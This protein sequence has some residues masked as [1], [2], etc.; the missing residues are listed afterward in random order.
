MNAGCLIVLADFGESVVQGVPLSHS[1]F[2]YFFDSVQVSRRK[3]FPK[4]LDSNVG[5]L[6]LEPK[7]W[8]VFGEPQ[9]ECGSSYLL[10]ANGWEDTALGCCLQNARSKLVEL[11][12]TQRP[13]ALRP[14]RPPTL[15]APPRRVPAPPTWTGARSASAA[16]RCCR[17]SGRRPGGSASSRQR[18]A[19]CPPTPSEEEWQT[20]R[21]PGIEP[22][23]IFF[24]RKCP[25]LILVHFGSDGQSNRPFWGWSGFFFDFLKEK[26]KHRVAMVGFHSGCAI[27]AK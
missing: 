6:F 13:L 26:V 8:F 21:Q 23:R 25:A 4:L 18:F 24:L 15:Q 2:P 1:H 9:W 27:A 12:A 7:S 17:P 11:S 19:P 5:S 20:G 14:C 22:Q 10:M 3:V 16:R